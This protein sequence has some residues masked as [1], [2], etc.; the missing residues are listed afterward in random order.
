MI[1]RQ[2]A[3][4]LGKLPPKHDTRTLRLQDYVDPDSLPLVPN[5]QDWLLDGPE[6]WGMFRNDTEP[7]C[8]A[9][10]AAHLLQQWTLNATGKILTVP[11]SSVTEMFTRIG[12][13]A[14]GAYMLDGLRFLQQVGLLDAEGK[15]H[16]ILAYFKVNPRDHAMVRAACLFCTGLYFGATLHSGI[17]GAE[18]WDAPGPSERVEGGHAMSLGRWTPPGF[19]TWSR[20]QEATAAWWDHEVDELYGGISEDSLD[21][22][23]KSVIGLDV[24]RMLDDVRRVTS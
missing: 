8:V 6:D 24:D 5:T 15:R 9:A 7:V 16:K 12:G 14:N 11:D 22:A 18:V 17:W 2:Q 3:G 10:S 19:V 23:G 13:T 21:G 1:H 20:D 4:P